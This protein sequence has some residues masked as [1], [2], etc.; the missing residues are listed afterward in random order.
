[1]DF[2]FNTIEYITILIKNNYYYLDLYRSIK[3][4]NPSIENANVK[5]IN[6]KHIANNHAIDKKRT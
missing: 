4:Y 1:M 2:Y 3:I 6:K 5:I